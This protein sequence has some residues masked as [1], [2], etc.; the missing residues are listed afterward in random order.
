MKKITYGP[1]DVT[2]VS[3]ALER[4]ALLSGPGGGGGG[5][6]CTALVHP[7]STRRAVARRHCA[8]ASVSTGVV[9]GSLW[10]ALV[11]VPSCRGILFGG[12]EHV[13][14][15]WRAYEDCCVLTG[16]V[17]PFCGLPASLCVFL[18]C[19]DSLT[20]HVNGEEGVWVSMGVHCVFFV[21]STHYH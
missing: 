10:W 11:L 6:R 14:V 4:S 16:R 9:I 21:A 7:P 18:A 17:S 12:V 8:G 3:W 13:S 19:L 20:S 1:G 2:D 15:M 5:G